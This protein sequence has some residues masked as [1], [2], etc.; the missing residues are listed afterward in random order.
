[1]MAFFTSRIAGMI[2]QGLSVVL[3]LLLIYVF[4]SGALKRH[5]LDAE[6][7]RLNKVVDTAQLNYATAKANDATLTASIDRQNTA[8]E[9]L[10]AKQA[11]ASVALEAALATAHTALITAQNKAEELSKAKRGSDVCA[12]ADIS[13]LIKESVK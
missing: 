10:G 7:L 12:D 2:G 11:K 8:L 1:M 3:A 13:A 6:I 5:E 9:D 4:V